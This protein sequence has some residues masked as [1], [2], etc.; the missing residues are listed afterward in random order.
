MIEN[1]DGWGAL[2]GVR[3]LDLTQMLA[4]P[5]GAMMLADQGAEV[6]KI[7]SPKGDMCRWAAPFAEGDSSK[8]H[9]GYFQSVNRNKKSICLDLKTEAGKQHFLDLVETADIV[10]ENFRAGVMD[11]LGLPY[12]T[13]RAINPRIVYGALSGFGN[14]R[15]GESPY[16][17]WPAFD[18]VAQAMGGIVGITGQGPDSP[19]KIGPG[20]GDLIPGMY[21]AFGVI[22]AL[23]HARQTGQGQFVDISMLDGILS[24]C[25]RI[26]HQKSVLGVTAVPQGNHHPFMSPFGIYPAA[27]GAVAIASHDDHFFHRLATLLDA[28]EWLDED[29]FLTQR[30]RYEKRDELIDAIAER[31]RKK[32]KAE[33]S[34]LLAGKAP[35]GPVMTI[36]EIMEDPHFLAREMIV[37]IENPG[38]ERPIQI[39]GVPV[40]MTET[41]GGVHSRAPFHGEH[42]KDYIPVKPR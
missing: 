16:S 10:I 42:T 19:A 27:D 32:T 39:A 38:L 34:T 5:F 40:K 37:E 21:L 15:G 12:E 2:Q 17:D 22:S 14:P 11:R 13:L 1:L 30:Q 29:A 4:G 20:V 26:V 9:N 36:D 23:V 28:E 8:T 33:L 25:E 6:I 31:T 3:V 7:E 41:P 18:V 24:I 35:Y